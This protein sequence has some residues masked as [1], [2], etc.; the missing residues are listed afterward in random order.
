M[1][2]KLSGE[3]AMCVCWKHVYIVENM[4]LGSNRMKH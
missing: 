1:G 2:G 4:D 3:I